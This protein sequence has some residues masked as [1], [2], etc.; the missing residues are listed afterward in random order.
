MYEEIGEKN[1]EPTLLF[2]DKNEAKNEANIIRSCAKKHGFSISCDIKKRNVNGEKFYTLTARLDGFVLFRT[3][4]R[5]NYYSSKE[6]SEAEFKEFN[7]DMKNLSYLFRIRSKIISR[8]YHLK[9]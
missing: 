3:I 4:S 6:K 8:S 5:E 7:K 2:K 1:P 9:Q